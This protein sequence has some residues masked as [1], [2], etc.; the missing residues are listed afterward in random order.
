MTIAAGEL[1]WIA[2][3][4]ALSFGG[5]G[6][7]RKIAPVGA[8]AG[9]TVETLLLFPLACAYLAFSGLTGGLAFGSGGRGR[10]LLLVLAGPLTVLPLLLF[11]GAARRLP[12]SVLGLLQYLTP[13]IQ[14]GVGAFVYGE[15]LAGPRVVGFGCIWTGLA[16][17]IVRNLR[18]APRIAP[19][20]RG[21]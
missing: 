14:F 5:Y 2:L 3:V 20:N 6:M 11:T 8:V 18:R 12:L 13:T 15:R 7:L 4:I 21:G 16:L 19:E 17:L 10:D 1:P 9:L